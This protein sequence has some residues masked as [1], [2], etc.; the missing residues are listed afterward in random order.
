MTIGFIA[1]LVVLLTYFWYGSKMLILAVL[2]ACC[3]WVLSSVICYF[4]PREKA[5]VIQDERDKKIEKN[6][7]YH[8]LIGGAL[9]ICCACVIPVFILG[10]ESKVDIIWLPMICVGLF[11]AQSFFHALTIVI[12]YRWEDPD[13]Q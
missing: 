10:L 12:D 3:G 2:V 5:G 9:F 1:A 13:V 7:L 6:A 4:V 11:I 8:G